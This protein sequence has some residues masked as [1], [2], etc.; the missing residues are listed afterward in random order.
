MGLR[1][2]F[3]QAEFNS[4]LDI[5]VYDLRKFVKL[6]MDAN[7]NVLEYLFMPEDCILHTTP[8]FQQLVELRS[9]FLSKKAKHT[10]LGYAT[11]QLK[12]LRFYE[13]KTREEGA[14]NRLSESRAQDELRLGYDPKNAMHLVRLL[15]TGLDLLTTGEL[16]VR[17]KD[18][19]E[20]LEIRKGKFKY[21][22]L[23]AYAADLEKQV[24]EAEKTS[25]LPD[26]PNVALIEPVV[27]DIILKRALT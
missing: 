19:A 17:R 12:Q 22:E 4:P 26:T 16:E 14:R 8:E 25:F 5:V 1:S 6:A 23:M 21:E 18:A 9:H 11:Q 15:R 13:Q 2:P 27:V 3:Q 7:P 20:L 10:Y 24:K